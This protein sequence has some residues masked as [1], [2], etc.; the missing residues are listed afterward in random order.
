MVE[1]QVQEDWDLAAPLF[2]FGGDDSHF[3]G[4]KNLNYFFVCVDF[5]DFVD[6]CF[7]PPPPLHS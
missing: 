6:F 7:H 5:V 4:F 3:F 2:F 1:G